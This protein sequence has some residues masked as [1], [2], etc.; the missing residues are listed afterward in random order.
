MGI[1]K[2]DVISKPPDPPP[3]CP[4]DGLYLTGDGEGVEHV[5]GIP[6]PVNGHA[7]E[8]EIVTQLL[9]EDAALHLHLL[10]GQHIHHLGSGVIAYQSVVLT[11]PAGMAR[12]DSEGCSAAQLR[13]AC[14]RIERRHRELG[15]QFCEMCYSMPN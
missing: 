6:F 11:V 10:E 15:W 14:A 7:A 2:K 3:L 1:H 12:G 4:A 8:G 13:G 9:E 5:R